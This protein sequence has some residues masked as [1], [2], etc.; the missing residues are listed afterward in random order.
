MISLSTTTQQYLRQKDVSFQL[1]P[2]NK[3]EN[4]KCSNPRSL[5]ST[6]CGS[7]LTSL[8]V[9]ES[10]A[11]DPNMELVSEFPSSE[12]LSA[13]LADLVL[14]ELG[15]SSNDGFGSLKA[16]NRSET[17]S[18]DV[19][20]NWVC[21][22]F[23]ESRDLEGESRENSWQSDIPNTTWQSETNCTKSQTASDIKQLIFGGSR[24]EWSYA[25]QSALVENT[26]A[27]QTSS[28]ELPRCTDIS[29]TD[30]VDGESGCLENTP[31]SVCSHKNASKSLNSLPNPSVEDTFET[32]AGTR[33][34]ICDFTDFPSSE[35]L[36]AF[37]ANIESEYPV[38]TEVQPC[39]ISNISTEFSDSKSL[40]GK[41]C[42]VN[43]DFNK[44]SFPQLKPTLPPK[45]VNANTDQTNLGKNHLL[46]WQ[47][48]GKTK[49]NSSASS[50]VSFEI[51]NSW[52][53][54]D[55][56]ISNCN[57]EDEERLRCSDWRSRSPGTKGR[58]SNSQRII[59]RNS[60]LTLDDLRE[61]T[62]ECKCCSE[63]ENGSQYDY[64][65][66]PG[67][68]TPNSSGLVANTSELG[69]RD[70]IC[71]LHDP[72][73]VIPFKESCGQSYVSV[74]LGTPELFSQSHSLFDNST[75]TCNTNTPLLFSHSS[76]EELSYEDDHCVTSLLLFSGS[77]SLHELPCSPL[78]PKTSDTRSVTQRF[79]H[80]LNHSTPLDASRCN[81][82]STDRNR[83]STKQETLH[84]LKHSTPLDTNRFGLTH[85]N[86]VLFSSN[87]SSSSRYR[88]PVKRRSV[89][90]PIGKS[91]CPASFLSIT[92]SFGDD[93]SR[94][95]NTPL[96]FSVSSSG[97]TESDSVLY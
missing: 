60:E 36:E 6:L 51:H 42:T 73:S 43:E 74:C 12:D 38:P 13:F 11:T 58:S 40:Q 15:H 76:P 89:T 24:V 84:H 52:F 39:S 26:E 61:C 17:T 55:S 78:R 48:N 14:D 23:D 68:E 79:L 93:L 91:S 25:T 18:Q 90:C 59:E 19:A 75:S 4:N 32:D 65:C 85:V 57:E 10:I 83:K 50:E 49:S 69:H 34:L 35:D 5:H 29:V 95:C 20:E 62:D 16:Q 70:D 45:V 64:T 94:F 28:V 53:V 81:L 33:S 44:S 77:Q 7:N 30:T 54:D 92:S 56:P 97:V 72:T 22:R 3:S 2:P 67:F 47:S 8:G 41:T 66:S 63:T 80:H 46:S 21:A 86:R 1:P 37:L 27:W 88:T 31:L 82:S 96:L 9:S 87:C 71:A